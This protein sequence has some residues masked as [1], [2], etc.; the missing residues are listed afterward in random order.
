MAPRIV[1]QQ[2]TPRQDD[3]GGRVTEVESELRALT[4]DIAT[5]S[6]TVGKLA[7]V[8]SAQSTLSSTRHEELKIS[9]TELKAPRATNWWA[10]L[11]ASTAIL[12][13][14]IV[15]G[16]LVLSPMT[17]DLSRLSANQDKLFDVMQA[18][19]AIVMHPVAQQRMGVMEK[20][21]D[22]H[23]LRLNTIE[24]EWAGEKN[25]NTEI[26]TQIHWVTDVVNNN[27][28]ETL[29]LISSL[30]LKTYG[31]SLPTVSGFDEGP[32]KNK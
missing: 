20:T 2:S 8:V 3:I 17:K 12:S 30:W 18:H 22:G 10:L 11:S 26:E 15:L 21:V 23:D 6:S 5:V 13:L 25:R 14:V 29:R 1:V 27:K 4:A 19:E 32:S 24:Q 31:E 7:D 16:G 9:M 28:R